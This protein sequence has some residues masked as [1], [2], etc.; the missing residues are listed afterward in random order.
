MPTKILTRYFK[1]YPTAWR[2]ME[3]FYLSQGQNGLPEW[4]SY[5]FL[6][7]AVSWSIVSGGD[8]RK[9]FE[10]GYDIPVLAALGAL[11]VT[12]MWTA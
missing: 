9:A 12:E 11:M 8:F 10:N 4:P 6:P 3:R 7:V 5:V 1:K 2:T